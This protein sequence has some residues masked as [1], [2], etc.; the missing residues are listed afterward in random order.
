LAAASR[1]ASRRGGAGR[2]RRCTAYARRQAKLPN[3]KEQRLSDVEARLGPK[4]RAQARRQHA[5]AEEQRRAEAARRQ[6][7]A[8]CDQQQLPRSQQEAGRT[9]RPEAAAAAAPKQAPAAEAVAGAVEPEPFGLGFAGRRPSRRQRLGESRLERRVRERQQLRQQPRQQRQ[10][11]PHPLQQ[12]QQQRPSPRQPRQPSPRKPQQ[13]Q[14]SCHPAAGAQDGQVRQEECGGQWL[15]AAA[16]AGCLALT[17][18]G[19]SWTRVPAWQSAEVGPLPPPDPLSRAGPPSQACNGGDGGG[20]SGWRAARG[21]VGGAEAGGAP[22]T[23]SAA[24]VGG[25]GDAGHLTRSRLLAGP[26]SSR[27]CALGPRV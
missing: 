3:Q 24:K 27:P 23:A 17:L 1:G 2:Q 4:A 10:P 26:P 15:L 20:T 16:V 9:K 14:P 5:A 22:A 8:P 12:P 6:Q 19:L 21:R 25:R 11:Q 18:A 7:Q 13:E